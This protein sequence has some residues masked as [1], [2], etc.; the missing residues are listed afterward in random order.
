MKMLLAALIGPRICQKHGPGLWPCGR[1]HDRHYPEAALTFGLVQIGADMIELAVVPAAAIGL[2]QAQHRDPLRVRE[3]MNLLTEPI[4][5]L[6]E[7]RRM[8]DRV[9]QMIGQ[10]DH[11]PVQHLVDVGRAC[12]GQSMRS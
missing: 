8:G 9:P 4:T 2:L 12:H 10:A 7:G 6:G 1:N 5:D 11:M 3:R